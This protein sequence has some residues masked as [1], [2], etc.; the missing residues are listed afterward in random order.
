MFILLKL[1]FGG[2]VG[3]DYMKDMSTDVVLG[4]AFKQLPVLY[5]FPQGMEGF[6]RGKKLD[7]LGMRGSNTSDL[8]FEDTKVPGKC[9]ILFCGPYLHS[10][11]K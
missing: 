11:C 1:G 6:S 7:K 4:G 3:C 2:G 9:Q 5:D 8:I 10:Y